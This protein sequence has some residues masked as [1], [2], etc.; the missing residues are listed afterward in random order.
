MKLH[1][2]IQASNSTVQAAVARI[3]LALLL[4][5]GCTSGGSSP[6]ANAATGDRYTIDVS[7]DGTQW[8]TK[9]DQTRTQSERSVVVVDVVLVAVA[10]ADE[11]AREARGEGRVGC[12]SRSPRRGR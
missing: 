1:R 6:A 11:G 7:P 3:G 9:V 5:G 12:P 2:S 8:T 4:A 10:V